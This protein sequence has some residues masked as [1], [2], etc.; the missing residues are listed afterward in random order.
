MTRALRVLI[1]LVTTLAAV[2][3]AAWLVPVDG[4][5]F[6]TAIERA[7]SQRL[8]AAV[9]IDGPITLRLLPTPTLE[10]A[11]LRLALPDGVGAA[12]S[13]RLQV[14][15][16]PLLHGDIVPRDLALRR[17]SIRLSWPLPAADRVPTPQF[18]ARVEDGTLTLG[19]LTASGID[20]SLDSDPLTGSATLT[21]RLWLGGRSWRGSVRLSGRGGDGSASVRAA[22]DGGAHGPAATLSGQLAGDGT[23]SGHIAAHGDDLSQ[24]LPAPAVAFTAEGRITAADG[25]IS[26]DDM[27]AEI[28][29]AAARGAI[30]LR[31]APQP[32]LDVAL[33]MASL[34]LDAWLGMLRGDGPGSSVMGGLPLGIDVSAD[35]A[36]LAGGTLHG[37][38]ATFDV[39]RAGARLSE[40]DAVLPGEAALRLA[41][42]IG[43]DAAGAFRLDGDA[44]LAAPDFA[45]TRDW[46][47]QA[48]LLPSGA[49]PP[50]VLRTLDLTATIGLDRSRLRL[51]R[52]RGQ[53]DGS[54]ADGTLSLTRPAPGRLALAAALT[55]DRL[56]LDPW[57]PRSWPGDAGSP[58]DCDLQ[59]DAGA[60]SLRGVAL[61]HLRLDASDT[62][63]EVTLRRFT[64]TV[65]GGNLAA[66]GSLSPDGRLTAAQ[67]T[68]DLPRAASLDQLL[69]WPVPAG[70]RAMPLTLQLAASGRPEAL[71][72]QLDATLGTLS[73][74]GS[75]RLDLSRLEFSRLEFSGGKWNGPIRLRAPGARSWLA[76]AGL[77]DM[78]WL[79]EGSLGITADLD[80]DPSHLT[81]SSLDAGMGGL[82]AG[83]ELRLDVSGPEP[84]LSGRIAAEQL[85]LPGLPQ[86]RGDPLP[87]A[88]LSGW[89]GALRVTADSVLLAGV[90]TLT[91]ASGELTLAAGRLRLADLSAQIAGGTL[92]GM[93]DLATAEQPP[94][95]TLQLALR[96][97]SID[98][99]L[100]GMPVDLVGGAL[101]GSAS[102][103]ASG[104]SVAALLATLRGEAR[105]DV[106]S[107][108]LR[109]ISAAGLPPTL[110]DAA[111]AAALSGGGTEALQGSIAGGIANGALA[112][113]GS[114]LTTPGV[115]LGLE[116]SVDL[117]AANA[118]LLWSVRP[119][120]PG[121]PE[122][123]LRLTGPLKSLSR[124]PELAN[125]ARWRVQGR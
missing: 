42:R 32:R 4:A 110:P 23:L 120:L 88:A 123:D 107:G 79:G 114:R 31:V 34:D 48:G 84:A 68:L 40:F 72:A 22:F 19:G 63:G 59:L 70:L 106:H 51:D 102:L 99:A 81:L 20:A 55:L 9:S 119:D 17:P 37:L 14:A 25:L 57:A 71:S 77:G 1:V 27:A 44:H 96:G 64:A 117:A 15:L 10:A 112:I 124:A 86:R 5:R 52:L 33:T 53:I 67:L 47:A 73:V 18:S 69:P 3:V 93:A 2:A 104:H 103:D 121:S 16:L 45:Q 90:P 125:L 75:P 21:G 41:G 66:S 13:L 98:G 12:D 60:A 74:T 8:G 76:A 24:L 91:A 83:G 62:Q 82:R 6:H 35:A 29:G 39:D 109:G 30:A 89:R 105:V 43:R 116:G 11:A 46:L 36:T 118:D 87:L 54:R 28:A 95:L 50:G 92:S 7:A 80:A 26:A 56:D 49:T 65:Q 100:T 94:H 122:L 78:A 108:V 61:G 85:P 111:V 101:D 115:T 97:A 58:L 113:T 38:R